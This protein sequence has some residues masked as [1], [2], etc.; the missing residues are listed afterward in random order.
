[1]TEPTQQRAEV[2]GTTVAWRQAPPA[3]EVPV[4]YLHGVPTHSGDW[5]PFLERTGGYALDLPG[6]G[7]SDKP[8]H[9]PYSIEGY[10]GFLDAWLAQIG[11]DDYEL[12]VHDWG[13]VGLALAQLAPERLKR[14][15]IVNAVPLLPGYRWHRW[16]RVWRTPL[17]GELAMGFT[18]KRVLRRTLEG[19]TAAGTPP[20]EFVD[21]IWRHF[22]HGTQRAILK[23]YR[24][25][26]PD[27]LAAA[28][29]R[30]GELTAPALVVWGDPDP[31]IPTEFAQAYADALGGPTRV[32]VLPGA[33]HWPWIGRPAT[34]DLIADF[35]LERR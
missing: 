26:P 30:L 33:H 13:G 34:V 29:E 5:L 16:A 14:L 17:A 11:V 12:V 23:L 9:F 15:V 20:D 28:G 31:Y 19:T 35:L 32:E 2:A 1:M 22:D 10:A 8:A 27:V 24:S 18:L 25:A 21:S 6:F 4:V 3:G 7:D